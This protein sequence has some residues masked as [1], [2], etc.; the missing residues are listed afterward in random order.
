MPTYQK[1][2]TQ[3][4]RQWI[5]KAY[6]PCPDPYNY[7]ERSIKDLGPMYYSLWKNRGVN[8]KPFHH[9]RRVGRPKLPMNPI[10]RA[11]GRIL[12]DQEHAEE[13]FEWEQTQDWRILYRGVA[14]F[15]HENPV[16]QADFLE[17]RRIVQ[18]QINNRDD[19]DLKIVCMDDWKDQTADAKSTSELVLDRLTSIGAQSTR[20]LLT[21]L[22]ECSPNHTDPYTAR[23]TLNVNLTRLRRKGLIRRE[24]NPDDDGPHR[25]RLLNPR[26]KP[27]STRKYQFRNV[28]YFAHWDEDGRNEAIRMGEILKKHGLRHYDAAQVPP[29]ASGSRPFC[30]AMWSPTPDADGNPQ[31]P[32]GEV[33]YV[34]TFQALYP[35][36]HQAD[37]FP[38]FPWI[39]Y[40]DWVAEAYFMQPDD[41]T[42]DQVEAVGYK[43]KIHLYRLSRRGLI[44]FDRT[45]PPG[46][47][48]LYLA[49][50]GLPPPVVPDRPVIHASLPKPA[51]SI[52]VKV[53]NGA[54]SDE[55]R[56]FV[57][58][59]T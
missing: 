31:K 25:W 2:P 14:T 33:P 48:A 41:V 30:S 10:D 50:K 24:P 56:R 18:E 39:P 59:E 23:N 19:N 1:E 49:A 7:W 5:I 26:P 36:A 38:E 29:G 21:F 52:R 54:P 20:A 40:A 45:E 44:I 27:P 16:D 55:L 42:P 32:F 28:I 58:E 3:A 17:C 15:D 13:L 47:I 51:T 8:V 4:W 22:L 53:D 9:A 37:F 34:N 35:L 6:D 12:T 57:E 46:K 43:A 11:M